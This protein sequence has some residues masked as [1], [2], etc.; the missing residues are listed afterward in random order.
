ML[1]PNTPAARARAKADLR[2]A[3]QDIADVA[4]ELVDELASYEDEALAN[5]VAAERIKLELDVLAARMAITR[6]RREVAT[7]V[8]LHAAA[9]EADAGLYP[10]DLNAEHR[11]G[12][13]ELLGV[14]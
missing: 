1:Y 7:L 9:D 13:F 2:Q 10:A 12:S 14:R 3:L 8:K 5:D 4:G 6:Y 11:L